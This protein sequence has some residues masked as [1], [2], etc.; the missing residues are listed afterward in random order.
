MIILK[1][2]YKTYYLFTLILYFV[3]DNIEQ[4]SNNVL[5][6]PNCSTFTESSNLSEDKPFQTINTSE[7]MS[8]INPEV[9]YVLNLI[10]RIFILTVI[11]FLGCITICI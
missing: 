11:L 3:T 5:N 10:K 2:Y 9:K 1:I 8:A 7:N 4:E 6:I